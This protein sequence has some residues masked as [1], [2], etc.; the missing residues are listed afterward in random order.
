MLS[1]IGVKI[2][3][4]HNIFYNLLP[5]VGLMNDPCICV[6]KYFLV[7]LF[8]LFNACLLLGSLFIV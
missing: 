1:F 6:R 2:A 5:I 7:P 8:L 3:G 4:N